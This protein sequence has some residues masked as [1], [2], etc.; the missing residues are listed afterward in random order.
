MHLAS[1]RT[2]N[3][4]LELAVDETLQKDV[5]GFGE[6]VGYGRRRS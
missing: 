3:G 5:F 4:L 6:L 1:K 2:P